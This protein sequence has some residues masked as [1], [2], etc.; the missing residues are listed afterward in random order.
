MLIQEA[1][2]WINHDGG[3]TE[4]AKQ[5]HEAHERQ[6]WPRRGAKRHEKG[7]L[8]SVFLWVFVP[9]CGHSLPGKTKAF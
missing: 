4:M 3:W 8:Q 7:E 2:A 1:K 9:F 6:V 5:R